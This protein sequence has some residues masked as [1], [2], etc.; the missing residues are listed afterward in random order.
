MKNVVIAGNWKS[1]KTTADAQGWLNDFKA[2]SQSLNLEQVRIILFVPF[3][4]LAVAKWAI[5]QMSLPIELGAQDISPFGEGAYT[6]EINGLQIKELATTVLIGHSER[7]Q[8]FHEDDSLLQKKVEQAKKHGLSV[9]YCVASEKDSVPT[10]VDIVAYEPVGAIGS[11]TPEPP[12]KAGEM[13]SS[14]KQATKA[15]K[16]IYGGSVTSENVASYITQ[17][18]IDGVLPGGVSLDPVA[19]CSLVAAATA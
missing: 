6:G 1:N 19:F 18:P 9:I 13:I 16:V 10:G 3:T 5:G 11:G 15:E 2:H 14:I 17:G 8:Y 7:R 12:L 4:V